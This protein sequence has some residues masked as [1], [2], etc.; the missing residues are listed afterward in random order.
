[1]LARFSVAAAAAALLA[2]TVL[3]GSSIVSNVVPRVDSK[4]GAILDVHD[5]NTIKIGDTFFWYG[6]GYGQCTEMSSG[7]ASVQVGSCGFNLNHTVNL[8]TSTDMVNWTLVG[9]VLAPED[10]PA[11]IMFSPWV[12]LSAET[13]LYVLWYN[14]LP[15]VGGSGDFDAAFYAAAVSASPYGPFVTNSSH[16]SSNITGIAYNRLPDAPSVF[17]DSDGSAYVAFTHEDSHVNHV[18]ALRRDLLGPLVPGGGNGTLSAQIGAGNNEGILMFKRGSTYYIMLGL[19]CCFCEGGTNVQAFS[20]PHPLG[21]YTDLGTFVG[22]ADWQA[23][24]GSV[25]FTGFDY[26][27]YGDRWQSAPD[28][29]KAHDFS[30]MA[31]LTF[32]DDG[33]LA[34]LSWQDNVTIRY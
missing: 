9:A 15:V 24:T 18:Q 16:G 20:A 34:K 6:A 4:T 7:C 5:G 29:I 12:A 25:T 21:P 26:V 2:S 1:M 13:G 23:Q 30:Y 27:L 8:V 17:V 32:N 22:P 19:C 3:A 31:P 10:R 11:G 14:V 28:R 33:S